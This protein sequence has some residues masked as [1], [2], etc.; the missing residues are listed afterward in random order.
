MSQTVTVYTHISVD[1]RNE[2]PVIVASETEDLLV[3][4]QSVK[5]VTSEL[6]ANS[7]SALEIG[8]ILTEIISADG[9][10]SFANIIIAWLARDR[11]RRIKLQIGGNSIEAS[12]LTREEQQKLIDWFQLQTSIK[13]ASR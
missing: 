10:L 7:K 1:S 8:T 13:L 12:G 6:M 4:L 9:L 3:N 2:N 5:N 11:S